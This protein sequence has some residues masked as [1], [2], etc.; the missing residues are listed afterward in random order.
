MPAGTVL[1]GERAASALPVVHGGRL[2]AYVAPTFIPQA[3]DPQG[4]TFLTRTTGAI[5]WA[6]L[7]SVLA[8]VTLGVLLAR[9]LLAPLDDLGQGIRRMRRGEAP[10]MAPRGR[11]DEFGEVLSA[12]HEM[13]ESVARNQRA[14]RQL[15]ANLAHDL[16]TR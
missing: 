2:V 13:H 16:N 8:A 1:A 6:M 12:F 9:V 4:R 11:T 5:V 15:T 10:G 3:P 7:G 14:Q